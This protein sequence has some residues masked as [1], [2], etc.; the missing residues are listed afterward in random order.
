[1]LVLPGVP[2]SIKSRAD[3]S[4]VLTVGFNEMN[5]ERIAELF[6]SLRQWMWFAMQV[7]EFRPKDLEILKNIHAQ[8][9]FSDMA[10]PPGQRLRAV[11]YRLW[12]QDQQSYKDF[13]LY[14]RFR[15]EELITH[16]KSKL[17]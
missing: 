15:M 3:G 2:E 13:E 12:E 14:Y 4:V 7:D 17:P 9:D 1:M 5:P 8:F 16:F 11:F 6:K 10:K